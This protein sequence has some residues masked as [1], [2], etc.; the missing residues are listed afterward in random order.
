MTRARRLLAAPREPIGLSAEEAAAYL[1]VSCNSFLGAVRRGDMPQAR[2]LGSRS[3]WDADEL[4]TAFR[5]LPRRGLSEA[6][7]SGETEEEAVDWSETA[8]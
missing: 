7:N 5:T 3:L 6:G 2:L 1:G 4:R 8:P